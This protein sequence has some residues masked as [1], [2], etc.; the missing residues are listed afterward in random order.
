M[1]FSLEEILWMEAAAEAGDPLEEIAEAGQFPL[2]DVRRLFRKVQHPVLRLTP[3]KRDVL[4][5]AASGADGPSIVAATGST[6]GA[7]V[8]VIESLR[9]ICLLPLAPLDFP[10]PAAHPEDAEIVKLAVQG[11]SMQAIKKRGEGRWTMDDIRD[12]LRRARW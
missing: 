2:D 9:R 8:N 10:D 11:C 4:A 6:R 12:A 7:V 5:L 3:F 1:T